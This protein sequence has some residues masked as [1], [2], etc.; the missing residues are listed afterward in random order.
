MNENCGDFN[1]SNGNSASD[2][3]DFLIE[4]HSSLHK[5][6]AASLDFA[7]ELS[8]RLL[9][10]DDLFESTLMSHVDDG[11]DNR[12]KRSRLGRIEDFDVL[13]AC[14][15]LR[16]GFESDSLDL[17]PRLFNAL[18]WDSTTPSTSSTTRS[19]RAL[20]STRPSCSVSLQW[21]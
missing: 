21:K 13:K 5:L 20:L 3:S 17:Y 2:W 4:K 15:K 18:P 10:L 11:N 12:Q 1:L 14:I 6:F 9:Q 7:I 19:C 16:I 8:N